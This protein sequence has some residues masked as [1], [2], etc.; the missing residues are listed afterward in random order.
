MPTRADRGLERYN[1]E[2]NM[3]EVGGVGSVPRDLGVSVKRGSSRRG[4]A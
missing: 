3:M 4:W 2:T 1:P